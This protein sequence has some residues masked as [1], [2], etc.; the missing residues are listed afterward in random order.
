MTTV[1]APA[2]PDDIQAQLSADPFK[3]SPKASILDQPGANKV[4]SWV[5]QSKSSGKKLVIGPMTEDQAKLVTRMA[6]AAAVKAD[7]GLSVGK[8]E[9]VKGQ[10][11]KVTLELLAT[12]KRVPDM[13]PEAVAKRAKAKADRDAAKAAKV[14]PVASA[15]SSP[16]GQ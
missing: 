6:R 7:H 11:N 13:T 4:V 9:P 3:R 1:T 8:P 14:P 12:P 10:K 16:S 5:S 2:F 15:P